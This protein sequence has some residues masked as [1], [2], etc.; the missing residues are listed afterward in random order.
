MQLDYTLPTPQERIACVEQLIAETPQEKLTNQ[1]LSYMSDYILFVAD[2]NQT[3][4]ER[5]EERPIVTKNR[6][7]TVAKRQVSF[8]EVVS[9]LENGEDG[10]YANTCGWYGPGMNIHRTPFAGRNFEYYS[11]DPV[12]SGKCGAAA[13]RGVQ[14]QKTAVSM[15]HFAC[16][17]KEANRYQNDSRISERALREIYLK[18]FEIAVKEGKPWTVMSSY[19]LINGQH[20]SESYELLTGILRDEWGFDGMVVTD[21]G[22]KNDPV[23]EVKAG[24]D[25]KMHCGYPE[26]L[27]K[28]QKEPEKYK[29]LQVRVCG[30]NVYFVD[31]EKVLQDAFIKQCEHYES[32]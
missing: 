9:N 2:K 24:N 17:N 27:K 29:N 19:N 23:K 32:I 20:T 8:E 1:Y 22:V 31:L 30:W 4:K 6:E 13:I 15:K 14:S 7:V 3:K 28:A 25:L 11:E 12:V 18:G 5:K 10:L 16:N 26:D 21:W